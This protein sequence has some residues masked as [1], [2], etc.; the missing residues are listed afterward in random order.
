MTD[1][2]SLGIE[3]Q[4]GDV[5]KA[6]AELDKFVQAGEKAE[7]AAEGIGQS[8]DKASAAATGLS[9][10]ETKLAET[11]EEAKTRL[12]AMAMASLDS[13]EYL[14]SLASSVNSS[15]SAMDAARAT[16]TDYAALNRRLKA[17]ADALVG[18][19]DK[20]ADASRLAAA[21][22]GVQAD[23]LVKLLGQINPATAALARLDEQ[24]RQ[25]NQHRAA[26]NIDKD[27]FKAYSADIETARSKIKGFNDESVKAKDATDSFGLSTR[28]A[29]QNVL[30]LINALSS[31]NWSSGLHAIAR[32]GIG[33]G[34]T[35]AGISSLF[36]GGAGAAAL[37]DSLASIA[38]KSKD[39][40]EN[41]GEAG[42]SISDL[43]EKSNTAAES[44]ENAK[45]ALEALTASTGPVGLG[46]AALVAGTLA[47]AAAV[48]VLI[49]GYYQ[50]SKEVDAYNKSLI[51]TG[52]YAG[53]SAGQLADLARQVSATNGTIGDAAATLAKLAGSG[54][55]A[56]SS[57]KGIADA[58][59]AME[60]ATGRSVD[61]TIAEFVK[62]AKDPVAAAKELNDQYHFL[63]ASVYS[64]IVALKEQ[65]DTTAATDLLTKT[66]AET[67][68]DRSRQITDNLGTIERAWKGIKDAA[69]G[70]LDATLNI[71]RA[72]TMEQQ[73]QEIRERLTNNKGRDGRLRGLG[74]E[75]RDTAKDKATLAYLELQID[76]EKT[77]ST[78]LGEQRKIQD[79]SLSAMAKVDALT[80]SSWTNEQK[81]TEALKE[82]RKQLEAIRKANPDDARLN[83]GVIDK[84]IANINTRFKDPKGGSPGAVDLT[85]FN[86]S[87]NAIKAILAEYSNAQKELDALQKAGLVSQEEYSWKRAGL[88]GNEKDEITAAYEAEIDALESAKARKTTSAAQVIELDKKIADARTD[89]VKAQQDADS[90]L[91]VLEIDQEGRLKKQTLAIDSYIDALA[92]Q[93]QALQ[94]AGQRA[95]A[96]VGQG[97]RQNSLN[98]ELNGIEDRAN[99]QRLDLARDKADAARNM[100]ADE[101]N[102]KL[103]AINQS[104]SDLKETTLSN[105]EAM[106]AAQSD[107]R[108]GATSAFQNY[109]NSAR[110]VAGQT[111]ALFGNAFSSMEDAV[112]NF[113]MTGKLSFTDFTKSILADMARIATRQ[114]ASGLLSSIAS[115]AF[116]AYFGGGSNN[117]VSGFSEYGEITTIP[118]RAAGGS[119]DPNS[120]YEVNEKGPELF[121][122][123]GRSYLMTGAAGGS[124]TPLNTGGGPGVAAMRGG[125]GTSVSL[126]MPIMVMTDEESGRPEG[127]EL[128]TEAFQ[129][130]MQER[131]RT[132]ARE[133]IAK[134]WRQGGVSSRNVKG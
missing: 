5:T 68:Q 70:A 106:S 28:G 118:G 116:G 104:E 112:V 30:Q 76:A 105:Y 37:G 2:A 16:T 52:N 65:G 115:T 9:G 88:I 129:R 35:G 107:W 54:V 31:G 49:Y 75:T 117:G 124:V 128:D 10:A 48:G 131:M 3:V 33:A 109:L 74:Y 95:A 85:E 63:T 34:I 27:G 127:A 57:F 15:T 69:A 82:Y 71:G 93:N 12:L 66:Y 83:K 120:L 91:K 43:A 41:A 46:M 8:F 7:K 100:S 19:V 78:Y 11:T 110:D 86:A 59:A 103:A 67:V 25:L 44:T 92:R 4:T 87:Q 113:A 89:M 51:L 73:A 6:G 24:Q 58:A 102:Q 81:R 114:A 84:N 50:G 42:E 23:G 26:G 45:K 130:N 55:I 98:G 121:S 1:I 39:V 47:A 61:A 60:D 126:S 62:I 22:T 36:S 132:V 133:E 29:Q 80:K 72:L 125:G 32:L 108:N 14:K 97:D 17:D 96:G 56:S 90:K 119:V 38:D 20:Q 134:S 13:S 99:Q 53:T 77:K 79:D 21:A 40:T 122:Q 101:Y 64:Q 111:K 94:Q 18:T 123:G